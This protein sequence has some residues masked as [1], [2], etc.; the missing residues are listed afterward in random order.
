MLLVPVTVTTNSSSSTVIEVNYNQSLT[1]TEIYSAQHPEYN[2]ELEVV[3][4]GF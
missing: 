4:S 1:A 3:Y 2:L